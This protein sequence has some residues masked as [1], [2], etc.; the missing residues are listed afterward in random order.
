MGLDL[1]D[2]KLLACMST[3]S[4]DPAF[5]RGKMI[6]KI[7]KLIEDGKSN[8]VIEIKE[9]VRA[10]QVMSV[11]P[12]LITDLLTTY[13]HPK[14]H[15]ASDWPKDLES[16]VASLNGFDRNWSTYNRNG[17]KV[18]NVTAFTKMSSDANDLF[19]SSDDYRPTVMFAKQ[20]KSIHQ[21]TSAKKQY[22]KTYLPA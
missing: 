19:M 7:P 22:P 16:L 1:L 9:H 13:K 4:P 21:L 20:Y 5:V 14:G 17:V 18:N 6:D 12:T 3:K 15:T 11:Y 2:A 10:E 8:S